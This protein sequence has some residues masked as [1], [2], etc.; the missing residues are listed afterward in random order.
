MNFDNF[1]NL[2]ENAFRGNLRLRQSV[3]THTLAAEYSYRD[4]LFNGSLGF[5]TVNSSLGV[6]LTSPIVPLGKTGIVKLEGRGKF[7]NGFC[8]GFNGCQEEGRR[9]MQ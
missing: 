7:G 6:V 3:G 9:N 4:R 8:N 5:Q 1:P 2:A